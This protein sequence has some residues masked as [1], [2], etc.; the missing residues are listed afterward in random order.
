MSTILPR[1][2]SERDHSETIVSPIVSLSDGQTMRPVSWTLFY[3]DGT[4]ISSDGHA[5]NEQADSQT[6][7]GIPLL[8]VSRKPVKML[9]CVYRGETYKLVPPL[10]LPMFANTR[11]GLSLETGQVRWLYTFFGYVLGA[12]QS[13]LRVLLTFTPDTLFSHVFLRSDPFT[14]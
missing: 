2:F 1:E 9:E 12:E 4:M 6:I 5:W 3:A 10:P 8:M 14:L 13:G 7:D 11:I